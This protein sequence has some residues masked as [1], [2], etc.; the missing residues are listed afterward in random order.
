MFPLKFFLS[1][2]I[3][4]FNTKSVVRKLRFD[5][6]PVKKKRSYVTFSNWCWLIPLTSTPV[7]LRTERNEA[8]DECCP[9]PNARLFHV[10]LP[11][12]LAITILAATSA[13]PKSLMDRSFLASGTLLGSQTFP[14]L[15]SYGKILITEVKTETALSLLQATHSLSGEGRY[16]S[17]L[18]SRTCLE[19]VQAAD[20]LRKLV[21]LVVVQLHDFQILELGQ[22]WGKT[23]QR[24]TV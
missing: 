16:F 14:F 22:I 7:W 18:A 19:L 9:T 10:S 13:E 11:I 5:E 6:I 4:Q 8:K 2:F 21:E 3:Y 1:E 24:A 15:L 20:N 23:G 17:G 12:T